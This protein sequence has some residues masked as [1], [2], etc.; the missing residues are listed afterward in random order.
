MPAIS[1]H[2]L[3]HCARSRGDGTCAAFPD[4]I[5]EEILNGGNDHTE[6]YPG[7]GGLQFVRFTGAD[8][9]IKYAWPPD[10][11]PPQD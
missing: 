4:G 5:P 8:S 3:L 11:L 6:A 2:C 7:D 1:Q 9:D 10:G